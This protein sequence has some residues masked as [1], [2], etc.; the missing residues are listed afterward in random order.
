MLRILHTSD[1]HGHRYN[2]KALLRVDAPFDVWVDTGDFFPTY[3]RRGANSIDPRQEHRHQSSWAAYRSLGQR[4][5]DWLD[6]RPLISTPGNHDFISLVTL[7]R[8]FGGEAHRSTPE[9]IEVAGK[10]WAGFREIQWISGEWPGEI[11]DFSDLVS[12]TMDADPHI[13]VT[14]S[15]PLGMLDTEPGYEYGIK[16]L[17]LAL[18]FRPNRVRAHFFGHAHKC[19]G[20]QQTEMDILFGINGTTVATFAGDAGVSPDVTLYPYVAAYSTG[21][22][23]RNISVDYVIMRCDRNA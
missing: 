10:T 6:G 17:L 9:G 12:R 3:G 18:M 21:A 16:G 13:L 20:I 5:V 11:S 19:G 7:V 4:L 15:P 8:R 2:Y 14:H 1:L 23:S 22:A